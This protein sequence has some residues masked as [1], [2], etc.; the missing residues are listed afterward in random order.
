[1]IEELEK[2]LGGTVENRDFDVVE[3]NKDV[4]DAVGIGGGE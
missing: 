3:V 2:R 1:L 4:V